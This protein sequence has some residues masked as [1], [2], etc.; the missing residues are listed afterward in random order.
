MKRNPERLA[1][2]F[3]SIAFAIFCLTAIL[4]PA[5]IYWYAINSIDPLNVELTSVR[6]IV[7]INNPQTELTLSVVDGNT[8]SLEEGQEIL[9]N[10]TSQAILTFADDS[11]LTMYSDTT[12]IFQWAQQP[13]FGFSTKPSQI[14]VEVRRG[15]VRATAARDRAGLT[16]DILT[17]QA[18]VYLGQGSFS[19]EVS[20]KGSQVI[21]RLGQADVV[22]GDEALMLKQGERAVVD[23]DLSISP[24]LPAAQN[25]LAES[26]FSPA[27]L[28]SNWETYIIDPIEGVTATA[29]VALFQGRYVLH[30]RSQGQDN[31]HTEV[32]V[33]Q[34][35]N[36]D[37][38]DFQ[39]LRLFAEVRLINQSLPGG[40]QLGSEFPIMLNIAYTDINGLERNWFHGFYYKPRLDNYILYDQPDNSSEPIAR[41]IWYPYES[42]NLLSTL[43]PT[44]P[45]YIRSI[46]IYASGWLY[47]AM[48]G[49]ISLLA[50]E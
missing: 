6:G 16:F 11:S 34:A 43:G 13:R 41:L 28:D 32:G 18:T 22:S 4:V 45:A 39:S 30:L 38:R 46:R 8:V 15:R 31:V 48:V 35:V 24:P 2:F 40:G 49:N 20:D 37:V 29:E 1:W 17:P 10:E 47:D 5:S 21:T 7:L 36:R 33:I 3:L 26:T 19:I 50:E 42:V 23:P 44:R 12:I 9:T 27:S 14:L 25:L